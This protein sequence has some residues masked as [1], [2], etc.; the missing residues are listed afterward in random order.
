M[1]PLL[2]NENEKL[3]TISGVIVLLLIG[4]KWSIG[5]SQHMD[6]LFGDEAEYMRNGLDLFKI[7]RND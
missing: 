6:I 2:K 7:L 1:N 4:I 3:A 5:L